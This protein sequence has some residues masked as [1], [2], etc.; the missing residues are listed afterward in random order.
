M[1]V[2]ARLLEGSIAT[3]RTDVESLV[4]VSFHRSSQLHD[5]LPTELCVVVPFFVLEHLLS[6]LLE[7]LTGELLIGKA[8]P[9]QLQAFKLVVDP[10]PKN[11]VLSPHVAAKL[12]V[13]AQPVSGLLSVLDDGNLEGTANGNPSCR[14]ATRCSFLTE[15]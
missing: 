9:Y 2:H 13:A 6:I 12:I 3:A 10:A 4:Q 11:D 7:L 14:C 5:V 1:P 15:S 8:I